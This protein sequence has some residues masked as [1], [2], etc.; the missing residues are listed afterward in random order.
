[1]EPSLAAESLDDFRYIE[2]LQ[3]KIFNWQVGYVS[4]PALGRFRVRSRATSH[5]DRF[6]F[7]DASTAYMAPESVSD[8]FSGEGVGALL[9]TTSN[10]FSLGAIACRRFLPANHRR[11]REL[12][13]SNNLAVKNE[14]ACQIRSRVGQRTRRR[15]CKELGSSVEPRQR[16]VGD[17][18][19]GHGCR[20]PRPAEKR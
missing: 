14:R 1:M 17:V 18:G 13:L 11:Q 6:G 12:E 15:I 20:F 16:D 4:S 8:S 10:Y 2:N 9:A 19:V 3:V 7:E 5:V